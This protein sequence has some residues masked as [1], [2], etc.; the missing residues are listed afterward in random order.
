MQHTRKYKRTRRVTEYAEI[1]LSM[2][3]F[4]DK[5]HIDR[6]FAEHARRD[7]V[8]KWERGK[9]LDDTNAVTHLGTDD[10]EDEDE[11]SPRAKYKKR[12]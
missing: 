2:P 12:Y 5:E 7:P 10:D 11:D 6:T 9:E 3:D 4:Y 8:V 1:T